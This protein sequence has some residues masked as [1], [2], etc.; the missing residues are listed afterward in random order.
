[1]PAAREDLLA[2]YRFYERQSEGIGRYF[3]DSLYSDIESLALSAGVHPVFFDRYHRML[4]RRFPFAIYY[5]V[6][7]EEVLVYA[8]LDCRRRPAV[9]RKRLNE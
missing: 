4:S 3:L 5:R 6:Y 1:L 7:G 9:L 2:G 8:V